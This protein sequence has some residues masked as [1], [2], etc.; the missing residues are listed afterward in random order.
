MTYCPHRTQVLC[1]ANT[2]DNP[3]LGFL[4]PSSRNYTHPT[5]TPDKP[6]PFSPI[7]LLQNKMS[8]V[9]HHGDW[10]D[11]GDEMVDGDAYEDEWADEDDPDFLD[12]DGDVDNIRPMHYPNI[13]S[14]ESDREWIGSGDHR[15]RHRAASRSASPADEL[16]FEDEL[17]RVAFDGDDMKMIYRDV[18]LP[19]KHKTCT[20]FE[21]TFLRRLSDEGIRRV[22]FFLSSST[23]LMDLRILNVDS[24]HLSLL[25]PEPI[26]QEQSR[27]FSL[28]VFQV[29]GFVGNTSLTVEDVRSLSRFL[30]NEVTSLKQFHF[31]NIS[32][33]DVALMQWLKDALTLH[34]DS[35]YNLDLSRCNIERGFC[36]GLRANLLQH[37]E[38]S[39][40]ELNL[41][42]NSIDNACINTLCEGLKHNTSL[43][44]LNL[45]GSTEVTDEGWRLVEKLIYDT[46]S[47]ESIS[48]SNHSLSAVLG[49]PQNILATTF[50]TPI[51]SINRKMYDGYQGFGESTAE[52]D[53]RLRRREK[54][55]LHLYSEQP[56]NVELFS[57]FDVKLMPCILGFL[58]KRVNRRWGSPDNSMSLDQ[59]C[60]Y[61]LIR[62]WN[63]PIL[64]QFPSPERVRMTADMNAIISE[65]A[66]L[67]KEVNRLRA[68]NAML[69]SKVTNLESE[70]A[71]LRGKNDHVGKKARTS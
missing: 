4:N 35:L 44:L 2:G 56:L 34:K 55:L 59:S 36:E 13:Y 54:I 3:Q 29:Q 47:I 61:E 70:N 11:A 67:L 50:I 12:D 40:R 38:C 18:I 31:T 5:P 46:S 51:L 57:E 62:K 32:L 63:M 8:D 22:G 52:R 23:Q 21:T 41:E 58:V 27:R 20:S 68:E 39:L 66:G 37:G 7:T 17:D 14:D 65:N 16:D 49:I 25:F 60:I 42:T 26:Q 64:Y 1:I 43:Q 33:D 10:D 6:V 53:L 15:R 45:S 30:Q 9:D 19:L 24:G 28:A 71:A 48:N 69:S